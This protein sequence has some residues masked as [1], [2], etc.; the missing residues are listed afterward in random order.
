ME[1]ATWESLY[2]DICDDFGFDSHEDSKAAR[3]LNSLIGT[4]ASAFHILK[5]CIANRQVTI[6]GAGPSLKE[7]IDRIDGTVIT[8]DEA[9]SI[10]MNHQ[11]PDIIVTD[12][13]GN[14]EDQITANQ[15]GCIVVIHAHGDNMKLL[16]R[17][18]PCF[19]GP[20]VLTT[21]AKPFERVF[22]FGGFTDGD[23]AYLMAKQFGANTIQLLGFDF[24]V[25]RPKKGKSQEIKRRKLQWARRL[26]ECY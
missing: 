5:E 3:L 17:Y 18:A 7:N 16:R 13:D 12:L 8:A 9:T 20:F 24:D 14:V 19:P 2:R 4:R 21:Q 23:R 1:F 6:C 10:V 22:N 25:P 26:I 11:L 15:E